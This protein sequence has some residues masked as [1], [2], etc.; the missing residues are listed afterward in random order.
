M[1][2]NVADA[3][4]LDPGFVAESRNGTRRGEAGF[5]WSM[6]GGR[7]GWMDGWMDE[8]IDG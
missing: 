2:T 7:D 8:W 3:E 4:R 1:K 6:A 5:V